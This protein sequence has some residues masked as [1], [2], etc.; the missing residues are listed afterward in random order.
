MTLTEAVAP[1]RESTSVPSTSKISRFILSIVWFPF[2]WQLIA[3]FDHAVRIGKVTPGAVEPDE[4]L[5][6]SPFFQ[7]PERAGR[8][9]LQPKQEN[10]PGLRYSK[11]FSSSFSGCA[12]VCED[13]EPGRSHRIRRA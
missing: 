1:Q 10:P 12:K 9:F 11:S 7:K 4:I 5:F 8:A 6:P 3:C 2:A 13:L